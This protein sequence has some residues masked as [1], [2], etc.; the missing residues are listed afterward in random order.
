M[1]LQPGL[2]KYVHRWMPPREPSVNVCIVH[3]LGEHGGRYHSLAHDLVEAGFGVTAF[4][5]QGHGRSPEHRGRVR[6]YTSLLD[7]IAAF[8]EWNRRSFSEIPTVLFGHSMGGNLVIN[9]GLR[10]YRQPHRIIASSPMIE[11]TRP[12]S[13]MFVRLARVILWL[14]PNLTLRSNPVAE[15]LMSDPVEQKMLREDE[16]FHSQISLRLGAGLLDSGAWILQN[17]NRLK[18]KLLLTH[19][20]SDYMTSPDASAEFAKRAGPLCELVILENQLHDPFRDMERAAVIA[21]YVEFIRD[22][23]KDE[24][25]V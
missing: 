10:D 24:S 4:D 1:E 23:L 13:R 14:A 21:R 6:S 8:L 15:R 3:G 20:T 5:Q 22:S 25:T 11:Q 12:P 16:L 2:Q 17:A 19:G 18:T 9:Y 7:E